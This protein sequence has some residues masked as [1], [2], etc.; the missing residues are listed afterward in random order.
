[1][2]SRLAPLPVQD[3]EPGLLDR[4]RAI[5]GAD[6]NAAANVYC[7]LA[8]EPDLFV[9]WL[10]W[11][12]HGLRQSTLEPRERELVILRATAISHGEYPF[13]QHTRIGAAIGLTGEELI[14]VRAGSTSELW[15]VSDS[16][17]I[18]AVEDLLMAGTISDPVWEAL[19]VAFSTVQIMDVIATTAFY[20]LASWMLNV[21]GTPLDSGQESQLKSV[22]LGAFEP[23]T[24]WRRLGIRPIDLQD[25]PD[26]LVATTATWPRFRAREELRR[27]NVY[28]TLANHPALFEAIGPF[29][30]YLLV[31]NSLSDIGREAV[32]IRSCVRDR[33]RYPYRQHVRIGA[34][35]GLSDGDLNELVA[36]KPV[37]DDPTL[38]ILVE[39]TDELHDT[40]VLSDHTWE[41]ATGRLTRRQVLDTVATV[42]FYGFISFVL[43]GSGTE[44]EP[45]DVHL[46]DDVP[47]KRGDRWM[48]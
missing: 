46:P 34:Q 3:W 18:A 10:H 27:A 45:G 42:G 38:A 1:M 23:R 31:D 12:G 33:G 4:T 30:A 43:N 32:I 36:P 44:L 47:L 48:S 29:M 25:W 37:F 6:Y 22:T 7:T 20:R 5:L 16:A 40:N 15:D 41:R 11:G 8:N 39:I 13:T 35:A 9:A 17:L 21:C 2:S 24:E 26:D 19:T 28:G 14:A